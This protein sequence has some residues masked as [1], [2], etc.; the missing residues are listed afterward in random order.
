MIVY[1]D[2]FLIYN[3]FI[4]WCVLY[5]SAL[6]NKLTFKCISILISALFG[7]AL[8]ALV[9]LFLPHYIQNISKLIVPA[10]MCKICLKH[11]TLKQYIKFLFT[12]LLFTVILSGITLGTKY[13]FPDNNATELPV[14]IVICSILIFAT[15]YKV[16]INL[17]SSQLN[18]YHEHVKI[19]IIHNGIKLNLTGFNDSGNSLIYGLEKTPVFISDS[20]TLSPIINAGTIVYE[21][22]K[23]YTI[24]NV[25]IIKI[26][27]PDYVD[28]NGIK[29]SAKIGISNIPLNTTCDILLNISNIKLNETEKKL[30]LKT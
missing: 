12:Y 4:N 20:N 14:I 29:I 16:I 3:T 13:T 7:A 6:F 23:C 24:N 21:N 1:I 30:C 26:F 17:Y 18:Q 5:F 22:L 25:D 10:I 19:T 15:L 9:L 8:S 28:I 11:Y 2:I 27:T